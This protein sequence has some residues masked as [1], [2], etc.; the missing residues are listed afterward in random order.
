[1]VRLVNLT[2]PWTTVILYTDLPLKR[3]LIV[4]TRPPYLSDI[5]S[6]SHMLM[7][8]TVSVPRDAYQWL[9]QDSTVR[10]TVEEGV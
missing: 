6:Q 3:L 8:Y 2:A 9:S 4:R 1:M 5:L 10:G 7:T